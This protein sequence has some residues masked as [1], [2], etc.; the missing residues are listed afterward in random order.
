MFSDWNNF[1][2]DEE[3]LDVIKRYQ[4]MLDQNNNDFF[5]LSEF[6]CIIDYYADQLNFKD[7]LKAVKLALRLHSYSSSLKLKYVQL[8]IE[9]GKPGRALSLLRTIADIESSN[10]EFFLAKGFAMN[11]TGKFR[12]AQLNF[13]QALKLCPENKDD[14][15]YNIAQS[16]IQ[17]EKISDAIRYLLLAYEFN[18]E[19]ILVIYD[20]AQS[21]EKLDCSEES[22]QYYLKYLDLDPFAENVWCNLGILYSNMEN[23]EKAHEA[24]DFAIAL[25]PNYYSAYFSKAELHIYNNNI[26]GAISVYADLLNQD[27]NNIRA[28]CELGNCYEE[29]GK[30]AQ[31]LHSYNQALLISQDCADAWF[32]KGMIHYRQKRYRLS[33]SS[34]NKAV[35]LQSANSDY[36][37][38]LGEA[39]T[40]IRKLDQAIKAYSR[41]AELNP[42]DFEAWMSCAQIL[43]RKKRFG[44]AVTMLIELYQRNQ[45]NPT[46]NYRL[47]A[48]HVYLHD[49]KNACKYFEK[50]IKLNYP[51]HKDMFK[52]Y[53]KTKA[54]QAFHSIIENHLQLNNSLK[55]S[56]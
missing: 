7:A 56:N 24:F 22:I 50:G 8:L 47:A 51:E 4:D 23:T 35:N 55:V 52:S 36:W 41:A 28:L 20:L 19:N 25:N 30:Y 14:M 2:E 29:N 17:V 18:K 13:N 44:E 32:G 39:L 11:L 3:I 10:C 31:A 54:F 49:Y 53:P 33:V 42:H 9:T 45:E 6:E 48:Y 21:Y 34:F 37:F 43:F 5:D 15:A 12:E 27:G 1:S 16:F 38:M 40:R 26:D 46:I